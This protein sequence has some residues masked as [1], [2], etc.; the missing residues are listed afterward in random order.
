[1]KWVVIYSVILLERFWRNMRVFKDPIIWCG[2]YDKFSAANSI[3]SIVWEKS[4]Y[5]LKMRPTFINA[6]IN[7][8]IHNNLKFM[9]A[10]MAFEI[11]PLVKKL[12]SSVPK[13]I[14]ATLE[15][16]KRVLKMLPC[17]I[18]IYIFICM[19]RYQLIVSVC[20]MYK[21]HFTCILTLQ[22]CVMYLN[23]YSVQDHLST[24]SSQFLRSCWCHA[25]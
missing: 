14:H 23:F 10:Y 17:N 24:D 5:V 11:F 7:L 18:L 9:R 12:W 2:D 15:C 25:N 22:K 3:I 8:L 20:S 4:S 6:F 13:L 21:Y 1:M 16:P 19:V